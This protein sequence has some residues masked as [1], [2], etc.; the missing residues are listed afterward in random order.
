ME[1]KSIEEVQEIEKLIENCLKRE[2]EIN[3]EIRKIRRNR[4]MGFGL[5]I[6]SLEELREREREAI[7]ELEGEIFWERIEMNKSK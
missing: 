3:D 7:T 1:L 2:R 4:Y 5:D 6:K